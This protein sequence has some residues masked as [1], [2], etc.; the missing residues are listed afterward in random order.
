ML[1]L[2]LRGCIEPSPLPHR[3][4]ITHIAVNP[5]RC[6]FVIFKCISHDYLQEYVEEGGWEQTALSYSDCSSEPVSC[7]AI[8]ANCTG[9]LVIEILNRVDKIC[10]YIVQPHSWPKCCVSHPVECLFEINEDMIEVLLV[11]EVPL[12]KYP[13]V[14]DLFCSAAS[15]AE[16]CLFLGNDLLC[17]WFQTI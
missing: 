8:E 5:V 1:C 11:L 2:T 7:A 6:R 17:F 16:A 10:I 3:D 15:W 14:E 13:E 12:T 9:G 4:P